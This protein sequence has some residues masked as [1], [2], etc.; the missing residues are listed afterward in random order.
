MHNEMRIK[1]LKGRASVTRR[2]PCISK[3]VLRRRICNI[4]EDQ[5]KCSQIEVD[6]HLFGKTIREAVKYYLIRYVVFDGF[7]IS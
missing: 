2:N 5:N 3:T 4:L 7:P 1:H 6:G